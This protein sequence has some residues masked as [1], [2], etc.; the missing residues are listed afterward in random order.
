MHYIKPTE[1]HYKT[2][3]NLNL[4]YLKR[5]H[6]QRWQNSCH[7]KKGHNHYHCD[8]HIKGEGKVKELK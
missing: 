5:E 8:P 4:K 3:V 1:R 7:P 2:N 6:N